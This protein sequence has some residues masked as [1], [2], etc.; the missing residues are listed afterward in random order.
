M[1]ALIGPGTVNTTP[2]ETIDAF[3]D[4]G[5]VNDTLEQGLDA[6]EDTLNQIRHAGIDMQQISRQLE[7]E[8]IEKFN[9]PFKKMLAAIAEKRAG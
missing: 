1:E 3:R 8:A 2:V 4:H 7:E 6:A 5:I 9:Q